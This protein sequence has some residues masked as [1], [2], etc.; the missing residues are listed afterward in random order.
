MVLLNSVTFHY[1]GHSASCTTNDSYGYQRELGF[2]HWAMA[3]LQ[4]ISTY[5]YQ[6]VFFQCWQPWW[7]E[8]KDIQPASHICSPTQLWCTSLGSA[9]GLGN[10][11]TCW[12]CRWILNH[13]LIAH[14]L[15][16]PVLK[17]FWKSVIISGRS[18]EQENGVSC[19]FFESRVDCCNASISSSNGRKTWRPGSP[20][21]LSSCNDTWATSVPIL[22]FLGLSVLDLGPMYATDR[23]PAGRRQMS[24]SI[25]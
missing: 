12:R 10:V 6:W 11:A 15:P 8:R 21:C 24:D 23:R 14:L 25:A 16:S 2:K 9:L 19:F 7:S 18:Y 22:V 4:V 17:K 1:Q 5:L 13:R 20:T 3:R